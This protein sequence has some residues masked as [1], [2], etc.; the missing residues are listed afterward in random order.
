M[1]RNEIQGTCELCKEEKPLFYLTKLCVSCAPL[2]D[3][4]YYN[5]KGE[6]VR[7]KSINKRIKKLYGN[8]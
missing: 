4:C 5:E 3:W 8:K 1:V 6:L 7:G 2:L